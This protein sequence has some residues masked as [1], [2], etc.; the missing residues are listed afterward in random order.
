MPDE[1]PNEGQQQQ[2]QQTQQTPPNPPNID[3][4]QAVIQAA[5]QAAAQVASAQANPPAE[6]QQETQQTQ[7]QETKPEGDSETLTAE[8]IEQQIN[9][10]AA[11]RVATLN[12]TRPLIDD[13]KFDYDKASNADLLKAALGE[14]YVDGMEEAEMRGF[15]RALAAARTAA[16]NEGG[17]PPMPG[18]GNDGRFQQTPQFYGLDPA[19]PDFKQRSEALQ[20]HINEMSKSPQQHRFERL[21]RANGQVLEKQTA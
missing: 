21:A 2:T 14:E 16:D 3:V 1:P 19:H 18:R 7:Q 20:H 6:G 17:A 15:V 8:Q 12:M 4:S 11:E 10:R 5:A 9:E 13:D